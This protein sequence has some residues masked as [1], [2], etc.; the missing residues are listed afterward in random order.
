MRRNDCIGENVE[1]VINLKTYIMKTF[2]RWLTF[3][4]AAC[5]AC[6][7]AFIVIYY[8]NKWCINLVLLGTLSD[9]LVEIESKILASLASSL[10]YMFIGLTVAPSNKSSVASIILAV[11]ATIFFVVTNTLAIL[12]GSIT[13]IIVIESIISLIAIWVIF[14]K[15]MMNG[16]DM[17][18]IE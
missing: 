13:L 8:G 6:W 12:Q 3:V 17:S 5:I 18:K 10:A 4:P 9:F 7:L 15:L 14:Y 2:L 1:F 16:F 11:L